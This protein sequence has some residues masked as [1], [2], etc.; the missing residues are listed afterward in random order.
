ME[1]EILLN[2]FEKLKQYYSSC[3]ALGEEV[4]SDIKWFINYI[5]Q[6][7]E[8]LEE[9]KNYTQERKT[10]SIY[11]ESVSNHL[12]TSLFELDDQ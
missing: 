9:V 2:K 1:G 12:E 11:L 6:Q 7:R 5:E 3:S 8:I 10:L 4:E